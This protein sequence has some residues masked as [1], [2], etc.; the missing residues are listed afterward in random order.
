MLNLR[1]RSAP[2][3]VTAALAELDLTEELIRNAILIGELA[4]DSCTISHPTCFPGMAAWGESVRGFREPLAAE[5]W[6]LSDDGNF[7][8]II[9][10]SGNLAI[11]VASGDDRTG[12]LGD[13]QPRTKY[14]TGPMTALA[15]K[16]N[17]Q[18]LRL[19]EQRKSVPVAEPKMITWLL[20][21]R[22]IK[23][24]DFVRCELSLPLSIGKDDRVEAW[25][26]RII[27]SPI[28]VSST[29]KQPPTDSGA[30]FDIN[31]TR[32]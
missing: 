26:D 24:M 4:R 21:K 11:G 20:V 7:P 23:D 32:K 6:R 25:A 1:I 3:E 8:L 9:H 12:L 29:A 14:P 18:Q 10:P 31:V 28:P 2:I 5:G 17:S 15:I 16:Q 19:F 27:L 30:S 22:R 13:P